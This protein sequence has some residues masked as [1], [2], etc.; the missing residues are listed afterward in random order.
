MAT[1]VEQFEANN[2]DAI[3]AYGENELSL[4]DLLEEG[5]T[6]ISSLPTDQQESASHFITGLISS[7]TNGIADSE[8]EDEEEE[9]EEEDA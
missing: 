1:I 2:A 7:I 6:Y 4:G 5:S 3:D 9:E 8:D